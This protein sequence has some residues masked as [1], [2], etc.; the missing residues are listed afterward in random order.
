[1]SKEDLPFEPDVQYDLSELPDE[2]VAY[3]FD[4]Y[5]DRVREFFEK[6]GLVQRTMHEGTL[7]GYENSQVNVASTGI[8]AVIDSLVR[9]K[10]RDMQWEIEHDERDDYTV[11]D[12]KQFRKIASDEL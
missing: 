6:D 1:M 3:A 4:Q 10:L 5:S 9:E 7:M 8:S 12:I 2:V 11:T